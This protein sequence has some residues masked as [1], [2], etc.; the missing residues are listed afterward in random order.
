MNQQLKNRIGMVF[1]VLL[2][3]GMIGGILLPDKL[4]SDTERRKLAQWPEFSWESI[5]E[6]DYSDSL[7]TY[8]LE[9]F[10]GRDFFR[11][12]KAEFDTLILGKT[13]SNG[14]VKIHNH[15]FQIQTS[16]DEGQVTQAGEAFEAIIQAYFTGSNVYYGVIPDKN[17]FVEDLPR[18]DYERV[19]EILE[20]TLISA[21][22]IDLWETLQLN[23]YYDTDL[24]AKQEAL[25]PLANQLLTAM[26]TESEDLNLEDFQQ[27]VATEEFYGGYSANSA[28]YTEPDVL[29]YLENDG[30]NDAVVYDYETGTTGPIYTLDKLEGMD[31]YDIFIGG[32]RALLTIQNTQAENGKR[33]L[34]FRDSFGSSIA[35]LLLSEYEEITLIDLRYVSANYAMYLLE[36][37]AGESVTYD[38]VLFLYQVQLLHNSNSMKIFS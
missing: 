32:A 9:Q 31:D 37:E 21:T 38:D 3:L 27:L 18:Y 10:P 34:I 6:N 13:D 29:Y 24:H 25:L 2:L 11:T 36:Q 26:G 8:L 17:Y 16:Y 30:I 28:Y 23:S 4:L 5:L 22:V 7:E 1:L 15:L 20:E 19:E 14:Y 33:L 35:P 12:I